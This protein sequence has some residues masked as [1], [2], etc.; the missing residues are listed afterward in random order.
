MERAMTA[1]NKYMNVRALAVKERPDLFSRARGR[2]WWEA[3]VGDAVRRWSHIGDEVAL[4]RYVELNY[5]RLDDAAK[6]IRRQASRADSS[7][8]ALPISNK[9]WLSW[10]AA[11]GDRYEDACA[12]IEC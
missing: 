5:E 10:L 9:D 6:E 1:R 3:D 8:G 4:K 12:L 2:L 11:H 7:T